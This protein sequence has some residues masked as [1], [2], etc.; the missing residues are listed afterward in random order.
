[1]HETL[2]KLSSDMKTVYEMLETETDKQLIADTLE[3][4]EGDFS[5]KLEGCACVYD[6]LKALHESAQKK[7]NTWDSYAK[8]L[9]N[10]IIRLNDYVKM[11]MEN[12]GIN[13][14]ETDMHRLKIVKNG[15]KLPL[16][17]EDSCVPESYMR[18]E[19]KEI[20]DKEKIRA[21]LESGECLTFARLGE[22]G[23]RLKID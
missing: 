10:N 19:I 5:Y 15:G 4:L 8:T 3:A 12:A 1:M 16:K 20:P 11:C 17:I 21:A 18:K 2:M 13:E 6:R 9:E 7:A 22:R 23:I 14:I